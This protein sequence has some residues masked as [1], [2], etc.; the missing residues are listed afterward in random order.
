MSTSWCTTVGRSATRCSCPSNEPGAAMISLDSPIATVLG[1][2]P[3]KHKKITEGLGLRTVRDL[4]HH[5]PRRY[6]KTGELTKVSELEQGQMLTVVGEIV[7]SEIK[8]HTDR[9]TGRV[10]YRLETLLST[11]GPSL[12]MTFFARN[13]YSADWRARP[14]AGGGP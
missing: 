4:L 8:S 11:D 12:R 13:K 3:A 10:A 7:R 14:P 6:V 5:F 2:H 9:R 1:D